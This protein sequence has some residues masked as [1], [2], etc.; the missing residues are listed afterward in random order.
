VAEKS[1]KGIEARTH[2][3]WTAQDVEAALVA[4]GLDPWSYAMLCKDPILHEIEEDVEV[5]STFQA[6]HLVD[7]FEFQKV[8]LR[9]GAEVMKRVKIQVPELEWN[10]FPMV[11]EKNNP[12]MV[13]GI[14]QIYREAKMVTEKVTVK[15]KKWVPIDAEKE[16]RLGLR[17][18]QV[19][20]FVLHA[21]AA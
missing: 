6:F 17:Y 16:Y 13:D 11:D 1:K 7:G 3:G 10:E 14:K 4:E 9:N 15:Q 21:I 5:D 2:I 8:K 20:A 19:I 18:E 12:V